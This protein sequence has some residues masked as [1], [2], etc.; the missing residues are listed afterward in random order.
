VSHGERKRLQIAVALWT[1]PSLLALEESFNHPDAFGRSLLINSM[2]GFHRC[3][4]LLVSHDTVF[5]SATTSTQWKIH[6]GI[7]TVQCK[8]YR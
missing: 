2:K 6:N 1:A 4:L 5:L 8:L 7:L 3:A